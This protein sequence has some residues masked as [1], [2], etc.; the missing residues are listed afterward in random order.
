MT[1]LATLLA[2]AFSFSL[3]ACDVT[4]VYEV[5]ED[6]DEVRVVDFSFDRD[7]YDL[8]DDGRVASFESDDVR[9]SD[10]EAIEAALATAGDGAL[11]MLYADNALILDVETTGQTYTA[12]P[13]TKGFEIELGDGTPVVDIVVTYTYAF[14]NEDLYFDVLSSAA[15]D[16]DGFLPGEIDL[17]LVTVQAD[18]FNAKKA[19]LTAAGKRPLDVRD[20]AQ[21]AAAFGL[22]R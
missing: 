11:V 15:L 16:F 5:Y 20:Y 10:R 21:V 1:R 6:D 14:D 3:A 8:S 4:E 9:S 17:R 22:D 7:D 18:V 2:L 12:L 19:E 13:V